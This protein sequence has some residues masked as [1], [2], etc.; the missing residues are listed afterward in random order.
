MILMLWFGLNFNE[1]RHPLFLDIL[2]KTKYL[3]V[4]EPIGHLC[5]MSI[6]LKYVIK[7]SNMCYDNVFMWN[8]N[9]GDD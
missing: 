5:H 1:K 9:I 8:P 2:A 4:T 7:T 6:Y 3:E